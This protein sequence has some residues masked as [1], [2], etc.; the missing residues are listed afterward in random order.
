MNFKFE[1]NIPV[2]A[3]PNAPRYPFKHLKIGD[4]I[5]YECTDSQTKHR[6]YKAAHVT[7][8]RNNWRIITR[9]LPEG[10]RVWRLE[11]KYLKREEPNG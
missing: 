6:A 4:S 10:V 7:A 3:A 9:Q 2:P 1:Q 5:L 8:A 11:G